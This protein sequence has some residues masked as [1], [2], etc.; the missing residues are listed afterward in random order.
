M[1][2]CE[3]KYGK[4]PYVIDANEAERLSRRVE[5]FRERFGSGRSVHLTMITSNGL[6]HNVYSH[7]VQSEVI[8]DDLFR[9]A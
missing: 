8:L 9:D 7:S 5:A 3:M 4:K 2:V 6:E 1:N